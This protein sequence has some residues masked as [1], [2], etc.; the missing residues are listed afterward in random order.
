MN[1][2]PEGNKIE[3]RRLHIILRHIQG[4][5]A[6]CNELAMRLIERGE[7]DFGRNL[8]ANGFKHDNG[9]FSGIEWECLHDGVDP[10]LFQE[11]LEHHQT[12]NEHH[13]EFWRSIHEMPRIYV[14]EMVCDWKARSN[15]FGS[16]LMEWI[17]EKAK[18][19]WDFDCRCKVGKEVRDFVQLLLDKKF[20]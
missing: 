11:A 12:T 20:K 8:I 19:K 9:K 18:V 17:N 2:E 14:A 7:A 15:E 13:P 6:N 16:D 3:S 1:A 5:Q 4:V 10:K